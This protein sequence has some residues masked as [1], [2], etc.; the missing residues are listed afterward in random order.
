MDSHLPLA[1]MATVISGKSV[2]PV[3]SHPHLSVSSRSCR[4]ASARC[5]AQPSDCK[6]SWGS[7]SED[8]IPGVR[9]TREGGPALRGLPR[10]PL[11]L[12]LPPE[13]WFP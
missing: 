3:F 2:P 5:P 9:G 1:Q 11:P 12:S 7:R 6:A 8:P 4:H 10:P 13:G